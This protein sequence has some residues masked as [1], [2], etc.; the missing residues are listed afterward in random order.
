MKSDTCSLCP[1]DHPFPHMSSPKLLIIEWILIKCYVGYELKF[2]KRKEFCLHWLKENVTFY[3][4]LDMFRIF[5]HTE[6]HAKYLC[7]L[8]CRYLLSGV[9]N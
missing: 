5:S 8:M 2:A 6:L 3:E 9:G 4:F 1:S 7:L